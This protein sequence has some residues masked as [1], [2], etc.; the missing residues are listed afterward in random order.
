[1]NDVFSP[2]KVPE[3]KKKATLTLS[4][5]DSSIFEG[6]MVNRDILSNHEPTGQIFITSFLANLV[7]ST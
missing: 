1:M 6:K 3:D 2:K 4:L 7:K 5:F